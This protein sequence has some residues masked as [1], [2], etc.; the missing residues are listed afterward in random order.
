MLLL[1]PS[2]VIAILCG[3]SAAI[4]VLTNVINS[5]QMFRSYG[6]KNTHLRHIIP[7]SAFGVVGYEMPS[8]GIFS[9]RINE[10]CVTNL[11]HARSPKIQ[12]GLHFHNEMDLFKRD[13]TTA[14]AAPG[15]AGA[16][17]LC[18]ATQL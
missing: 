13:S 11:S 1:P 10:T 2:L 9:Y 8:M 18:C 12:V 5:L 4:K 14:H 6:M 15:V 7:D 17:V 3:I 16:T